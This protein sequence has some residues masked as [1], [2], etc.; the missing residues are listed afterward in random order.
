MKKGGRARQASVRPPSLSTGHLPAVGESTHPVGT[1]HRGGSASRSL[2]RLGRR[3][4]AVFRA[5][6]FNRSTGGREWT[7]LAQASRSAN[8]R[9]LTHRSR[10]LYPAIGGSPPRLCENT[11]LSHQTSRKRQNFP[12][13]PPLHDRRAQFFGSDRQA[14]SFSHSL[15]PK[16]ASIS[17]AERAVSPSSRIGAIFEGAHQGN[18]WVDRKGLH[19]KTGWAGRAAAV[20]FGGGWAGR[21]RF[22]RWMSR[23][24]SGSGSV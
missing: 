23:R 8:D 7:L 18:Q 11:T 19:Y 10:W 2:E 20:I 9:N 14:L 16:R 1:A 12:P 22:M 17:P 24:S 5:S 3:R 21:A 15:R 13:F 6:D 4:V